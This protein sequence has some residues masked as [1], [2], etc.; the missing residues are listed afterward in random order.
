M[1]KPLKW[2]V[3]QCKLRPFLSALIV[4]L[5]VITPGYFRIEQAIKRDS[6]TASQ[7]VVVTK[8][9]T[10]QAKATTQINCHTR[11]TAQKNSRDRF[12]ELF[13]AL[14]V[15]LTTSPTQTLQQQQVAHAFIDGL[16]KAV[17]L[18]PT[19]EDVDCNGD[20]QLTNADYG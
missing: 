1:N 14:D 4:L 17:P 19:V 6:D 2:V 18:D 15:L 16:R 11:N 8:Q 5:I 9:Q 20:G 13:N 12:S 3:E 7:L 10:D